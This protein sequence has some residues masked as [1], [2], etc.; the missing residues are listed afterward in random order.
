MKIP[1]SLVRFRVRAP[2]FR[3]PAEMRGFVISRPWSIYGR[4]NLSVRHSKERA[5]TDPAAAGR[6]AGDSPADHGAL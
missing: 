4:H 1:V 2:L 3:S 5:I 6:A